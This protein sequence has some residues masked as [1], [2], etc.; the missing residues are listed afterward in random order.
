MILATTYA[1]EAAADAVIEAEPT[2]HGIA[3]EPIDVDGRSGRWLEQ[4]GFA[5]F[6][7]GNPMRIIGVARIRLDATTVL[8]IA[9]TDVPRTEIETLIS[10]IALAAD[11]SLEAPTPPAGFDGVEPIEGR[12]PISAMTDPS[13]SDYLS[14]T[15]A[16]VNGEQID[17]SISAEEVDAD[18]GSAHFE[19]PTGYGWIEFGLFRETIVSFVGPD[20]TFVLANYDGQVPADELVALA[21][22]MQLVDDDVWAERLAIAPLFKAPVSGAPVAD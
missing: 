16:G 19:T 10:S 9:A 13:A 20:A 5:P 1:D 12:S 14:M 8:D 17:L 4:E 7:A 21:E 3:G 18:V 2:T 6:S 22:S 11:G 15:L